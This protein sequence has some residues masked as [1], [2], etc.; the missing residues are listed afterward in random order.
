MEQVERFRFPTNGA[1]SM[2]IFRGVALATEP[3]V[4][5]LRSLTLAHYGARAIR[6]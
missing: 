5:P 3:P 6:L 4:L 2:V 1:V